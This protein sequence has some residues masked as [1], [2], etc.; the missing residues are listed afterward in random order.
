MYPSVLSLYSSV[1]NRYLSCI[2]T[3]FYI[4]EYT[5]THFDELECL[6]VFVEISA[7]STVWVVISPIS[8]ESTEVIYPAAVDNLAISPNEKRHD[9][10]TDIL[11]AV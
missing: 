10:K 4:H 8:T 6:P 11:G 9:L 2:V 7:L 1:L 5:I 3:V